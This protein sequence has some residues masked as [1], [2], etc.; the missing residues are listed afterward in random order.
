MRAVVN[1]SALVFAASL[2]LSIGGFVFHAIASRRLGV[3]DYGTLY[4]LIS[5]MGIA[6]LPVAIF[7]PVVT[8]Y[9]AEFEA[10]HDDGHMRG[11]IELI[12]R[13]CIVGSGLYVVASVL[14]AVPLAAYLHVATWA[15]PMVG[16]VAAVSAIGNIVRA[17]SQ[18]IHDYGAFAWSLIGEGVGKV[19]M[20]AFFAAVGL[21]VF[22]AMGAYLCAAVTGVVAI[23]LP[24][25]TRYRFI[26]PLP[27][28]LDWKRI[29]ATTGG[30]AVVTITLT[31]MGFADV[32]LV[33]H[34]FAPEQAG[35]YASASLCGKIL[36]YF[37]GFVPTILIPQAT[38]HH[39]RGER[40][41]RILWYAIGFL[42]IVSAAGVLAYH[43]LGLVLLHVLVGRAFDGALPILPTYAAAMAALALSNCLGSYGIATH[44]LLFVLPLF[45]VFL[46][47]LAAIAVVHPSL[48]VVAD[49]LLVGNLAM[50]AAVAV[51]LA[52]QARRDELRA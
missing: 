19:V 11:L 26:L 28:L 38:H 22:G 16:I 4:A 44:R 35:L 15:I 32:V 45:A 27:V 20:L 9:A 33:K 40:T 36:L 39:T 18:G 30:A 37:V 50:V 49:E 5:L 24:L 10:L 42:T 8:K 13:A 2:T 52:L 29:F 46:G 51:P 31:C 14:F 3:E 17:I 1:A 43:F 7:T 12:V 41:R 48:V 21:T 23:A 34:F 6:G 25:F 47:T